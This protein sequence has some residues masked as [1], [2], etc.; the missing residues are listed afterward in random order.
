MTTDDRQEGAGVHIGC[1][2]FILPAEL[3]Y[4]GRGLH[5]PL[6]RSMGLIPECKARKTF[7]AA[8]SP[9]RTALSMSDNQTTI[10]DEVGRTASAL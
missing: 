3:T 10:H 9:Q 7:Q 2:G 5:I 1:C 4:G 8:R 6:L